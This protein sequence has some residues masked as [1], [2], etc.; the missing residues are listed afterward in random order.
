MRQALGKGIDALISKVNTESTI[1]PGSDNKIQTIASWETDEP[2]KCQLF[3]HR[4]PR[5]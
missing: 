1:Y 3:Y 4:R 2:S 5:L